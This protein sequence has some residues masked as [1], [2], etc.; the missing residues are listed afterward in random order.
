MNMY[1]G[2]W[3]CIKNP[4]ITEN[5]I[6]FVYLRTE[7]C[8]WETTLVNITGGNDDVSTFSWNRRAVFSR[9]L[10]YDRLK[11]GAIIT[12]NDPSLDFVGNVALSTFEVEHTC[13][14]PRIIISCVLICSIKIKVFMSLL[15]FRFPLTIWWMRGD[16]STC[17]FSAEI[18]LIIRS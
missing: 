13:Q 2:N 6:H 14:Q 12:N 3:D 7:N 8:P 18:L 16:Q 17:W 11:T 9:S 1:H 5:I 15:W 10:G 4:F